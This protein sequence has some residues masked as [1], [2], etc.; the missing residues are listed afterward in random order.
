MEK[1]ISKNTLVS[2]QADLTAFAGW[3]NLLPQSLTSV[4]RENILEYCRHRF[5]AKFHPRSTARLLSCLRHFYRYLL[6]EQ[7]CQ[8][9]PTL[10][11]ESPNIGVSLPKDLSEAEVDELL[12]AP[13]IQDPSGLRDKTMLELLY[14]SGLRVTELVTLRLDQINLRQGVVRVIGKGSL[15]R[16]IPLGEQALFWIER[17]L[18]EARKELLKKRPNSSTLFLSNRGVQMTRQTFWYRIKFY[19]KKV[20]IQK[21]LSPHT[22]RHAFAT[23]LVNRGADLRVVQLLLGHASITTTEIYTHVANVRLKTL[24]QQHHP[25]G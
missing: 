22:L 21:N 19:A 3:C 15:E 9:D 18:N 4:T 5:E 23:H 17:Y 1:G 10:N 16:L 12:N 2:Y 24:H 11:I 20:N 6:R 14:A 25:R 8:Q 7:L 13:D